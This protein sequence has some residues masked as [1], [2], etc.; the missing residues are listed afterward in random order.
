MFGAV[1]LSPKPRRNGASTF[2]AEKTVADG[3][4]VE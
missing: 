1:D 2:G 3:R 4:S